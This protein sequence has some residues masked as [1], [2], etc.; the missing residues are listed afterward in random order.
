[1]RNVIVHILH[2]IAFLIAWGLSPVFNSSYKKFQEEYLSY[3]ENSKYFTLKPYYGR[4]GVRENDLDGYVD[5]PF[6]KFKVRVIKNYD[7]K[8]RASYGDYM[9]IPPKEKQIPY[10]SEE[11]LTKTVLD[12]DDELNRLLELAN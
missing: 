11:E 2:P 12:Y 4:M 7:E 6:G 1:M 5:M 3:D 10:P 9:K 8:L